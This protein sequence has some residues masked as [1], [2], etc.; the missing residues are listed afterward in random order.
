MK[1]AIVMSLLIVIWVVLISNAQATEMPDLAKKLGCAGCH[2]IDKKV[3]GPAWQDVSNKYKSTKT[4]SFSGKDYP[5]EEGV[6]MKVS[7]GGAGNWGTMAMPAQDAS[8]KKQAEMKELIKF[9]L[10]IA[11]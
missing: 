3:V 10:G 11:K 9:I 2:A 7:K 5:V 1:T 6:L 4:Y 8:G